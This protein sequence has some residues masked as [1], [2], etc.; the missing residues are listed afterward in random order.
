MNYKLSFTSADDSRFLCEI[1]INDQQTFLDLHNK[2][3][4]ALN[5]DGSQMASFFMLD[6]AKNRTQ[7]ISLVDMITD[8]EQNEDT[9][10]MN[11]TTI[12]EVV[13]TGCT[14]MEYVF[15]FFADRFFNITIDG[16]Y[17]A[18]L[19]EYPYCIKL[20]GEVPEQTDFNLE[21]DWNVADIKEDDGFDDSFMDEFGNDEEYRSGS[22]YGG[23]DDYDK[24]ENLDDY[25]DRL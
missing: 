16:E 1:V 3:I 23:G 5:Y 22:S 14:E 13:A 19:K 7:E 24:Y 25:I 2:I 8:E 10:I 4:E 9:L 18:P 6:N 11:K 20:K 15:D 17:A 21:D 12:H